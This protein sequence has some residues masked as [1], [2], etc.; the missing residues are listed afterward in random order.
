MSCGTN[1]CDRVIFGFA[2]KHVS[3]GLSSVMPKDS[4]E[5]MRIS[6]WVEIGYICSEYFIDVNN[7]CDNQ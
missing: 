1:F 2:L 3:V 4:V 5:I 7:N 6:T